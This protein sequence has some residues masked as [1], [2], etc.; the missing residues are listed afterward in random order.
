[1]L[2]RRL[3]R[4]LRDRIVPPTDH[5]LIFSRIYRDNLWGDPESASGPGS[6]GGRT[7][8]FLDDLLVALRQLEVRTLLD[9]PCGDFNWAAD[10][11]D[12]VDRYIGADVVAEVVAANVARHA[13]PGRAFLRLDL[14]RD[15]LPLADAVL[16]RDCLVH[17][18]FADAR[19]A[20]RNVQRSGSCYLIATTFADRT[21]NDDI[22]TGGWRPLNLQG[23]PFA[24]PAPL[25]T[26]D[27]R[28]ASDGGRYRDKR[29]GVWPV[30][31]LPRF[32]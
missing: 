10:V 22:R 14:T 29:L 30:A 20:L 9:V 18:S 19:A 16:C 26:I 21:F 12:A 8:A 11:A 3:L 32:E 28:C 5:G 6:T 15:S 23:P 7:A 17:F 1:M 25:L 31:A 27:E 13:G 24:F 4:A 2:T